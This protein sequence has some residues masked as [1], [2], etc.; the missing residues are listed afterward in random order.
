MG[1]MSRAE[2][3]LRTHLVR[4]AVSSALSSILVERDSA[5][6]NCHE[7]SLCQLFFP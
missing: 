4:Q 5:D 3:A 2:G 6:Q 1:D 7:L